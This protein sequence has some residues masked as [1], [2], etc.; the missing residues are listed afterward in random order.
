MKKIALFMVFS[1]MTALVITPDVYA[2]KAGAAIGG[3][4]GG[5]LVGSAL[6]RP[7]DYYYP[8]ETVVVHETAPISS[9]VS[10]RLRRENLELREDNRYLQDENRSLN[11][12]IKQLKQEVDVLQNENAILQKENKRFEREIMR[13][14]KDLDTTKKELADIKRNMQDMKIKT[15]NGKGIDTAA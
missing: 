4:I 13:L 3:F 6:S 7:R 2:G 15:D 11:R 9:T 10:N 5:T 12:E 1:A 14:E 8:R